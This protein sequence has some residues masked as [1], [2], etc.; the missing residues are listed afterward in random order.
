LKA[1]TKG[2]LEAIR[3][4]ISNELKS[5]EVAVKIIHSGVG[6]VTESDVMMAAA[7]QGLVI[8]F[9]TEVPAQ[10]ES[11]AERLRTEV[12][13][14]KI[15]YKLLDDLKKLLTG[16]LVPEK[17]TVEL[18]KAEVLKIFF[19]GKGAMIIGCKIKEGKAMKSTARIVRKG[20]ILGE[21]I[22]EN[23]KL[24]KEE[25]KEAEKGMECGMNFK[26]KIKLEEGD[27]LELYKIETRHKTL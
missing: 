7:S 23:L 10:V 17:V 1:D 20:E 5:S 19:T 3:E 16:L 24:V 14:Y 25:I 11:L 4:S 26:G 15:I 2:S 6:N 18:G 9:H 27:I 12:A 13:V 21:G 8:G 22:I